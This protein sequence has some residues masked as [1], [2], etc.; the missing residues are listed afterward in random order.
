MNTST[1]WKTTARVTDPER[2]HFWHQ[3]FD[4]DCIPIRSF[5]PS[6]ANLPGHPDAL[7]YEL[8]LRVITAEQRQ[9]LCAA[10]ADKF[11]LPESVVTVMLDDHGVPILADHVSVSSTDSALFFGAVL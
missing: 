7:I 5:M 8:D 3:I 2:R 10:L 6:R 4:T 9:R 11:E 1:N